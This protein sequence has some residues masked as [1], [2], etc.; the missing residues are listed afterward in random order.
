MKKQK[1]EP[2]KFGLKIKKARI[3]LGISAAKSAYKCGITPSHLSYLESGKKS[4]SL[5]M[6]FA[7]ANHYQISVCKL[8]RDS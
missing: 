5:P 6:L 8:I 3:K 4:P 2:K 7:L 1:W